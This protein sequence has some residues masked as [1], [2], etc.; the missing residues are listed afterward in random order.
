MSID[1]LCSA[2]TIKC[3]EHCPSGRRDSCANYREMIKAFEVYQTELGPN[4]ES[5]NNPS[6]EAIN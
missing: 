5:K 1:D 4:Y 3:N 6:E 2:N